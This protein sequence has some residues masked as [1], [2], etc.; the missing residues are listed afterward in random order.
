M[1][2]TCQ[3]NQSILHCGGFSQFGYC[4]ALE[5]AQG[6]SLSGRRMALPP[7][8][9]WYEGK[10]LVFLQLPRARS[11][12]TFQTRVV[13]AQPALCLSGTVNGGGQVFQQGRART[14]SVLSL[15]LLLSLFLTSL[16]AELAINTQN[17]LCSAQEQ[18][19]WG[20]GRFYRK[21]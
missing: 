15:L 4:R 19:N 8:V 16:W 6:P 17:W 9:R 10:A 5:T 20:L 21:Q 14:R 3:S 18:A 13:G 11:K 12:V 2:R 7:P 1:A